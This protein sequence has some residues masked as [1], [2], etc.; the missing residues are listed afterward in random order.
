MFWYPI[1]REIYVVL[2]VCECF[3]CLLVL[4]L[5][6]FF[7]FAKNIYH[8]FY[9]WQRN[10]FFRAFQIDILVMG[11]RCVEIAF[12]RL[13]SSWIKWAFDLKSQALRIRKI[14]NGFLFVF[15]NFVKTNKHL[16]D[17]IS[18]SMFEDVL[19]LNWNLLSFMRNEFI[20]L[21]VLNVLFGRRGSGDCVLDLIQYLWD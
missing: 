17:E 8:P 13:E 6:R 11:V 7:F 14:K 18:H 20:G 16:S 15:A 10:V 1:I 2:C 9:F 5:F 3:I 4:L 12:H 21:M 19:I